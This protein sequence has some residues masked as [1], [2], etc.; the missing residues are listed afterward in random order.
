MKHEDVQGVFQRYLNTPLNRKRFLTISALSGAT[1]MLGTQG[2]Q[3]DDVPMPPPGAIDVGEG[4]PGILN[5]A[6]ALEQLEAAF[7]IKACTSFFS[8]AT[9]EEKQMLTDIR[10]HEIAHRDLFKAALGQGAIPG[11]EFDF[12]AVNFTRRDSVL[13]TA[14]ALEDTGVAAYNGAGRY[15]ATK[16]YLILAGKIVSVEARH[17]AAIRYL[18][19]PGSADFAGDDV[20]QA[21]T[22]LDTSRTPNE[23]G[24]NS[25]VATANSFLVTK[26]SA[27]RLP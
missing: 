22:G 19:N 21:S 1:L 20:V 26:I 6:Y 9:G 10:D 23:G 5:F 18:L 4:D 7:Y 2:C 25:I 8:G 16:D 27:T 11:L 17:A 12:S 15:I 13:G 24:S 3:D 14:K